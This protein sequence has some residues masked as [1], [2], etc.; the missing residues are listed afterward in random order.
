MALDKASEMAVSEIDNNFNHV[1]T[2][3]NYI[4]D[5]INDAYII[6]SED[7]SPYIM[8]LGFAGVRA[9]TI[10][11]MLEEKGFLIGNGSACSSKKKENRNLSNMGYREDIIEGSVRISFNKNTTLEEVKSF[12]KAINSVVKEYK[13]KVR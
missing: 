6:S 8:M 4:R 2:L 13:E 9:E 10:L 11:H 3:N 1:K 7:N 12:V 5:N